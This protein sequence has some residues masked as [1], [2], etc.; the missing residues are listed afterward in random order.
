MSRSY[1]SGITIA[2]NGFVDLQTH[3]HLS[4]GEWTPDALIAHFA[5]A[6]F[7]AAAITD[8]DRADTMIDLQRIA[9]ERAF[10]LLVA[11]EMTTRWQDSIVDILCFGFD[12]NPAPLKAL[13]DAIHQAQTE[14]SQRVYQSL[15][16]S[17]HIPPDDE[18]AL[19]SILN[20]TTSRQP[21]LLF[22]LFVQHNPAIKD[23]LG[24][25]KEAGYQLCTN[26]TDA[27]VDAVHRCGGVALIAHPGRTDGF[28]TF[29]ADLLDQFRSEIP[30]DGIEV[31]HPRHTP[32][33]TA[34]YQ[35]YADQH[36]WFVSAGSDSHTPDRPPI[37]YPAVLAQKL[38]ERLDIR[39]S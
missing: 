11:A 31:Y 24:S 35:T 4:D 16:R 34:L 9:L 5:S 14:T 27:V 15:V 22:D 13:C 38:L 32:E 23:E 18:A 8:H 39:V 25:M 20:A 29:D 37:K 1:A 21:H 2:G 3:T 30:I 6:G 19:A 12:K 7:A 17:Q 28:A 10:P 36:G 26:P 33:Q